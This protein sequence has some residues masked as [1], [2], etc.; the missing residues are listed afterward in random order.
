MNLRR[1]LPR[2]DPFYALW[3]YLLGALVGALLVG[4]LIV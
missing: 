4:G 1:F 2:Q 3:I